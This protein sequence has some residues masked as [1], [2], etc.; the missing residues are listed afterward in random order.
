MTHSMNQ[1]PQAKV[2]VQ[3]LSAMRRPLVAVSAVA[4]IVLILK[5]NDAVTQISANF[6]SP[7]YAADEKE[8]ATKEEAGEPKDEAQ[9]AAD[10]DGVLI[11][12]PR[13]DI[14][15][16]PA[17]MS[18]SELSLLRDLGKRRGDLDARERDLEMRTRLL[19]AA[20]KRVEGKIAELKTLEA[21][22]EKLLVKHDNQENKKLASVVKVYEKMKPADAARILEGLSMDIQLDVAT[23]MSELRMAPILSKM[24]GKGAQ[25]L[26]TQ[27]AT[28]QVLDLGRNVN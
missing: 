11:E 23:R 18:Q 17:M 20:E 1:S 5:M 27:L 12:A 25:K 15:L 2:K 8:V 14:D 16:D 7:A 10:D 13:T 4:A 6:V 26:T 24:S 9:V 3:T 22:V 19:E 21:K 28:K